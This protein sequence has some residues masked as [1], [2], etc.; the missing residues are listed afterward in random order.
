MRAHAGF[1]PVHGHAR[2]D[3]A[4]EQVPQRGAWLVLGAERYHGRSHAFMGAT[5][6]L[7]VLLQGYPQAFDR[8]DV[9]RGR[10]AGQGRSK[11]MARRDARG[12]ETPGAVPRASL[13]KEYRIR[14]RKLRGRRVQSGWIPWADVVVVQYRDDQNLARL[15]GK[16]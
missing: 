16:I 13:R 7:Q 15:H 6:Q 2:C 9:N 8:G 12:D 14:L 1:Q 11:D 10:G 5:V 3:A 4:V